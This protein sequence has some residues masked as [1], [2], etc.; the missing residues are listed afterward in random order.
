[1]RRLT[2]QNSIFVLD[3]KAQPA[4]TINDGEELIVETWDAFEGERDPIKL[5]SNPPRGPA[6]GQISVDG[7]R[8]GDSLKIDILDIKVIGDAVHWS[9]PG[10][11]FLPHYFDDHYV[12]RYKVEKDE[13]V[14]RKGIRI[15]MRP[16]VGMIATT[17]RIPKPT[18]SDSG[19]YGG[20]IDLPELTAG[21][22]IFLPVLVPGALLA[23]GDCHAAVGDGAVGG[24]GAE[25]GAEIHLRISL[26]KGKKIPGPRVISPEYFIT[27]AP[28]VNLASAMRRAV[29]Q[30]VD[31]LVEET[32][33]N[34]Y[35]AYALLSVAGDIRVCRTFR[36]ISPVK[37]LLSRKVLSQ[38][39]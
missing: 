20:D 1:M 5:A 25:C 2:K 28:G 12:T 39:I 27:I 38:L 36:P 21:S 16:S 29:K 3:P 11:G 32:S 9:G 6:T 30:M 22:T 19:T 24:T 23:L 10:R 7:A 37:M 31:Y 17:P 8:P 13:I 4:L 18:A 26:E 15:P 33:M 35:E 14:S 34:P